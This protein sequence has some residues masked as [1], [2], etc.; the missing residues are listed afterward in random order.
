LDLPNENKNSLKNLNKPLVTNQEPGDWMLNKEIS[1]ELFA[2]W[3]QPKIDLFASKRNKQAE[4]FYRNALDK[5]KSTSGC[6]GNDAF[7]AKWHSEE[8]LYA[9]PPWNLTERL[10]DKLKK[11]RL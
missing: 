7:A 4:F 2:Q 6:L 8:L 9:H 1:A 11:E 5:S 10:I 3:G